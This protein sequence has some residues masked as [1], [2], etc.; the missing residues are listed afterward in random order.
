M[1][2]GCRVE[3]GFLTKVGLPRNPLALLQLAE[4]LRAFLFGRLGWSPFNALLI[5]SGAFG[6]FNKGRVI[7]AGGYRTDNVGEDMEL[8]VR[9]HRLQ[10]KAGRKY[11]IVFVPDPICWTEVPEDFRTLES[12]RIRWQRGLGQS[13]ALNMA[14]AFDPRAGIAGRVAFPFMFFF[15]WL[16]PVVEIGGYFLMFGCWLLGL[17]SPEALGIFLFVSVGMGIVLSV[18]ALLLEELSYHLYPRFRDLAILLLV[19]VLENFGYRQLISWWRLMALL[20]MLRGAR[21]GWGEMRRSGAWGT[22]TL[23]EPSRR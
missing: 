7:E 5:I 1:A 11:R 14:L 16:G 10:V 12:Q 15:E 8:V 13:L 2:N 19:V 21:A 4:Y 3:D 6:V 20:Q 23:P 22:E 9:L 18:A 17:L